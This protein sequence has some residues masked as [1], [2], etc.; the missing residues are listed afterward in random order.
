MISLPDD[1]HDTFIADEAE[2]VSKLI[3]ILANSEQHLVQARPQALHIVNS[4]RQ[5]T[6]QQ[7]TI[8]AFMHQYDLN[9]QEGT[10]LMCI[11]EAL[12]RIPD[13]E[14]A[15]K[16]IRDKLSLAHWQDYLGKSH[17]WLVNASTWGLLLSGHLVH[18][19][20][21][22]SEK[23]FHEM[24][25]R[26]GEPIVRTAIRQAMKILGHQFVMGETIEKAYKRSQQGA[27]RQD[28]HSFDMLGEAA[29]RKEEAE[30]F[31]LAY[32]Q[33]IHTLGKVKKPISL[34]HAPS[35][36]VKLSALYPR[37]EFLQHKAAIEA[38]SQKLLQL[39]QLAKQNGIALTIDAEESDRLNMSLEIFQRIFTH[40]D[41]KNWAGLGIAVQ[42]YQKR[43]IAVI[44]FL[45]LLAQTEQ[46]QIPVRLV[47]GAYWDTEIKHAQEQ[48]LDAYPVFTRKCNTDLSYLAC[49]HKILQA[50]DCFYA[51]FATHNAHTIASVLQFSKQVQ[52]FEFQRLHGMGQRLYQVAREVD[53]SIKVRVYAPVGHHR[54]LL[55][56]LVRRLLENGANTSFVNRIENT[57]VPVSKIIQNPLEM[58]K[59]NFPIAHPNIPLPINL[60]GDRRLN[61]S[62]PHL[63][64]P[65]QQSRIQ[66]AIQTHANIKWGVSNEDSSFIASTNP[67][68]E[69]DIVGY[70]RPLNRTQLAAIIEDATKA[71]SQWKLQAAEQ[72]AELLLQT[73]YLI[74][75]KVDALASLIVREGGRTIVNALNEVREAEDFCRYY[76]DQIQQGFIEPIELPGP[77]G[78]CNQLSLHGRGVFAC[79]SPWNFPVA[80][81]VGQIAAALAAG[82]S[83]IAKPAS[84]T[85][86]CAQ[87]CVDIFHQAGFPK[88]VLQLTICAADLFSECILTD[89]RVSGVCFTGSTQA[90]KHIQRQLAA[91]EAAIVPLIA[92][93]GGQ[94]VMIADSSA[95]PEQLVKDVIQSAFDSAGQRCSALRILFVQD[96]IAD[97]TITLLCG[98]MDYLI[99]GD[100]QQINTDIGPLIDQSAKMKIL[101]HN[102]RMRQLGKEIYKCELP[103]SLL[104]GNYVAPHV[105]EIENMQQL[106][107]EVF[108][109]VLHIIRY[110]AKQLDH[111]ITQINQSGYGLTLG[112]HSR[113]DENIDY[114]RQNVNVGNIYVNRNIIGAVVGVQPFGGE[115]LSG[116]GP[117][118]GG[119]HYLFAFAKEHT[120]TLNT[121]AVGGNT[122]LLNLQD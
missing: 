122:Q 82:N 94:N 55:P 84:L 14:T 83:V 10:I 36:S 91:R 18:Q 60:Y 57:D 118:A 49:A 3:E 106:K 28:L 89:E 95:L 50:G 24:L 35:I 102:Q 90:A 34:I 88:L 109:P 119:P 19:P 87:F 77:T 111:V 92:E 67:A 9:S 62:G 97:R 56:Y 79:I 72:R 100:P 23:I 117:K 81:F 4:V 99:I 1:L 32:Q 21:H 27:H 74:G 69:E 70:T 17:S 93:T 80:I 52:T 112:I 13:G 54:D 61:S 43:A 98:A 116:T 107:E 71:F 26:V 115:G 85:P 104:Q 108:G 59:N 65:K 48:G 25:Q 11:A 101:K 45:A 68:R 63:A 31:F 46:K 47:K 22:H 76:A 96:N 37:Y 58:V 16:L 33:A 38:I 8:E 6:Q 114:I 40:S 105:F 7:D 121:A 66:Q 53:S 5:Q 39:A 75:R 15:D 110:S 30:Q 2:C 78:E 113:I 103:M 42:A 41:L 44:D 20:G 12:L 29:I 64:N 51:Q 120:L 86:L 73:A